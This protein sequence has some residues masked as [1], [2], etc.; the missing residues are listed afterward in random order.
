MRPRGCTQVHDPVCGCDDRTHSNACAAAAEGVNVQAAG[1]CAP[2]GE[3]CGSIVCHDG[4]ECCNASCGI[5][6]RHGGVCT[7]EACE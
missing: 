3:K 1:E 7:H 2:P 4:M 6:V 5:C